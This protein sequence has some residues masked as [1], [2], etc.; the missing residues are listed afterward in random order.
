MYSKHLIE[1]SRATKNKGIRYQSEEIKEFCCIFELFI[2]FQ[3]HAHSSISN[4]LS[5]FET[6]GGVLLCTLLNT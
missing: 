4:T 2:I 5:T 3:D 6:L 1:C